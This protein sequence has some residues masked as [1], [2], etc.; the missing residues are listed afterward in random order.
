MDITR[1]LS[2]EI[3]IYL[4]ARGNWSATVTVRRARGHYRWWPE[5]LARGDSAESAT[6]NTPY[7]WCPECGC[8]VD[9]TR[10]TYEELHD[11]CGHPVEWREGDDER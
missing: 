11:V 9:G 5:Y 4:N 7:W 8:E 1:A 2:G 10:V 3:Q 6:P